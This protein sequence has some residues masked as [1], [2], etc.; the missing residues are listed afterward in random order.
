MFRPGYYRLMVSMCVSNDQFVV[1]FC[2]FDHLSFKLLLCTL[3]LLFTIYF[4]ILYCYRMKNVCFLRRFPDVSSLHLRLPEFC[5]AV[6][7]KEMFQSEAGGSA[8]CK[9]HNEHPLL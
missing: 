5:M 2:L 9:V 3:L 1:L 7:S 6:V 8:G 4:I